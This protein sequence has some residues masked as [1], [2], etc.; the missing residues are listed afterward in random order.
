M[1]IGVRSVHEADLGSATLA[2]HGIDH[3]VLSAAHDQQE[4]QIVARAG[5]RGSVTIATNMAGRG[6]DIKLEEGVAEL[7]GLVV[8]ICERHD[9]QR[10]DRQLMGR[11]RPPGRSRNGD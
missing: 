2:R 1:L 11:L 6:T 9:A 10:I 7:G 5:Q 8:M 3:T 4:A